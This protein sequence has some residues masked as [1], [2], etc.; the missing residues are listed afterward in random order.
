MNIAYFYK[1]FY[2]SFAAFNLYNINRAK[3][4]PPIGAER[5]FYDDLSI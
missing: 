4:Q 5:R 3:N 2:I 1:S